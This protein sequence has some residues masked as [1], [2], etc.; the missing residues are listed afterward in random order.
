VGETGVMT[1]EVDLWSTV[2][3]RALSCTSMSRWRHAFSDPPEQAGWM[4]SLLPE[5]AAVNH[6]QITC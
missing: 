4:A 1:E 3:S 2:L 6:L 5:D